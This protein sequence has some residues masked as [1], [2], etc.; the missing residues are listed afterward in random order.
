MTAL[1]TLLAVTLDEEEEEEDEEEKEEDEEEENV[2][3]MKPKHPLV[4]KVDNFVFKSVR[5]VEFTF[6]QIY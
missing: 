5:G 3:V 4:I 6:G 2:N 1:G